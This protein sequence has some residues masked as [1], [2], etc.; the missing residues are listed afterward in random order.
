MDL[1]VLLRSR[2]VAAALA[3]SLFAAACDQP[4]ALV[5]EEV[6]RVEVCEDL[7]PIGAELVRR[8]AEAVEGAPLAMVTGEAPPSEEL[9]GL[10]DIGREIDLRAARLECDAA[11]LNAAI[12]EETAELES[13]DPVGQMYLDIV[14]GGVVDTL[15]PAT[16][17]TATTGD[18]A[19]GTDAW[20]P[21]AVVPPSA[22]SDLALIQGVL[23]VDDTCVLLDE[24]GDDVLLVWPADRIAWDPV[25]RAVAFER[26]DGTVVTLADGESVTMSGGGSSVEEGGL[27]AEEWLVS[28][29]WVSEPAAACVTGTRWFVGD[30][31]NVGSG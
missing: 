22:G 20:G 29:G 30:V 15:P 27:E 23:G 24:R 5:P 13:D 9:A 12:N 28:I 14:R 25:S 18:D 3:F 26:T 17:S 19:G 8:M 16:T 4:P 21:L 6:E 31:V 10:R 1:P 7:V 2:Y 11:V